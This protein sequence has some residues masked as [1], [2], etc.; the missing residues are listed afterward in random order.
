MRDLFRLVCRDLGD[1]GR[2]SLARWTFFTLSSQD[3][4]ESGGTDPGRSMR[5]ASRCLGGELLL[6]FGVFGLPR[7]PFLDLVPLRCLGD[8]ARWGGRFTFVDVSKLSAIFSLSPRPAMVSVPVEE[9]LE[10]DR[11]C[12]EDAWGCSEI[13]GCAFAASFALALCF[14]VLDRV[15]M[16]EPG[17][18]VSGPRSLTFGALSDSGLDV[19]L[20]LNGAL[21]RVSDGL[22]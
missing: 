7:L 13:A 8:D 21:R 2:G 1:S 16:S 12:S 20:R 5:T 6:G 18:G 14:A 22:Q 11:V 17:Y 15:G 9:E 3:G 4:R 10:F 19:Q